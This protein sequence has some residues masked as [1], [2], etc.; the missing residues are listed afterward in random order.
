MKFTFFNFQIAI[1]LEHLDDP[2]PVLRQWLAIAVGRVWDHYEPARWRGARDNAHE[3][4]YELLKDP[5]PEVRAAAVFA[6]GTF[7]NSC[8]ERTEHANNLDHTI[9]LHLLKACEDG[10]PLVRRELVVA[11]QVFFGHLSTLAVRQLLSSK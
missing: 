10:S 3:K 1:C 7:I 4:L 5:V 11:L 2:E 9:A 8:D 6:L